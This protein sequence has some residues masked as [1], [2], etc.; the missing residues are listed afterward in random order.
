MSNAAVDVLIYMV[1]VGGAL[2]AGIV[3]AWCVWR[4]TGKIRMLDAARRR[5]EALAAVKLYRMVA[6]RVPGD[7]LPTEYI[8]AVRYAIRKHRL[9]EHSGI[10]D[11]LWTDQ[12]Y[13]TELVAEAVGQERLSRGTMEIAQ[14]E[15]ELD[16]SEQSERDETA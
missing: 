8:R 10:P 2:A 9:T 16:Q 7:L 14:N 15:L 6:Q 11:M 3:L 5:R 4:L 1:L 12:G 13:L